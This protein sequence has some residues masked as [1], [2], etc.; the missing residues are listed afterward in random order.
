M[1]ANG[2]EFREMW[3]KWLKLHFKYDF[4]DFI[5]NVVAIESHVPSTKILIEAYSKLIIYMFCIKWWF[6]SNIFQ[7]FWMEMNEIHVQMSSA[8]TIDSAMNVNI[9][10]SSLSEEPTKYSSTVIRLTWTSFEYIWLSTFC[11]LHFSFYR[12][13]V[14]FFIS[15]QWKINSV[16]LQW[17]FKL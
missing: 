16:P 3:E 10:H 15:K 7:Y 12:I 17:Q 1:S 9:K 14:D 11:I 4:R 13:I 5:W 2:W 8:S 6:D